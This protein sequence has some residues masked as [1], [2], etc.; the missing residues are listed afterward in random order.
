MG[1]F[2]LVGFFCCSY[3]MFFF[4]SV[5][6]FFIVLIIVVVVV[7]VLF[8]FEYIVCEW[9]ESDG[10]FMEEI[11]SLVVDSVGYFWIVGVGKFVC[12]DGL[13]FDVVKILLEV[14]L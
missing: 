6:G 8:F 9:Y 1:V 11:D 14:D 7:L 13:V 5:F 12:F 10:M 2:F 3:F 4:R